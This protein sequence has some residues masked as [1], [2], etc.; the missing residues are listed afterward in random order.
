MLALF[1]SAKQ[2]AN[3]YPIVQ[4]FLDGIVTANDVMQ[5]LGPS[6]AKLLPSTSDVQDRIRR[7]IEEAES[8]VDR[9]GAL[10]GLL[11][12]QQDRFAQMFAKLLSLF[13]QGKITLQELIDKAQKF[14]DTLPDSSATD[15]LIDAIMRDLTGR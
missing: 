6:V 4:Q 14:R 12:E 7:M 15:Q 2:L 13:K 3:V 5:V 10:T 9:I 1:N 8:S 11:A